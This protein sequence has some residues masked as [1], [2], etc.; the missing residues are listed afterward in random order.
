M[1]R[2]LR[3]KNLRVFAL[4]LSLL[5]AALMT[6]VPSSAQAD[7][8]AQ[9]VS[10]HADF[11]PE[12]AAIIKHEAG[13]RLADHGSFFL[14]SFT[15]DAVMEYPFDPG[16]AFSVQG[17]RAIRELF[18]KVERTIRIEHVMLTRTYYTADDKSMILEYTSR[19]RFLKGDV[20]FSQ[21][22]IAVVEFKAGR[23]V[24]FREYINPLNPLRALGRLPASTPR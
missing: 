21:Q 7:P 10:N 6:P 22:Y 9:P 11:P 5:G 19:P 8:T 1:T 4:T 13:S 24:L 12:L 23:I 20:S 18:V 16:G 2:L 15:D 3:C 17:R 14:D